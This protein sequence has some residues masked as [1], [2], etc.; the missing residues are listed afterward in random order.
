M[1]PDIEQQVKAF[2]M[3]RVGLGAVALVA[4]RS[5]LRR[6]MGPESDGPDNRMLAR[7]L[8]GRDVAIGLG[9]L[10]ALKHG[11]SVRGWLEAAAVADAADL[12]AS[13]AGARQ[14]KRLTVLGTAGAALGGVLW[15]RRLVGQVA[16]ATGRPGAAGAAGAVAG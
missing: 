8:G 10:F 11:G 13:L 4:P 9:T 2:A 5:A 14:M 1:V 16:A 6:W 15:G 7:M 12:L 3:G